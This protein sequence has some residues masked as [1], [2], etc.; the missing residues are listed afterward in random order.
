MSKISKIIYLSKNN[1]ELYDSLSCK[2][3][4]TIDDYTIIMLLLVQH[5]LK[6]RYYSGNRFKKGLGNRFKKEGIIGFTE[7]SLD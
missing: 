1:T 2:I 7:F 5:L 3:Q 4:N 6:W